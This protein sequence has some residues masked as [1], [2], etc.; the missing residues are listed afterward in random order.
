MGSAINAQPTAGHLPGRW[1]ALG[2]A[3]IYI[4]IRVLPLRKPYVFNFHEYRYNMPSNVLESGLST[5]G[6][7]FE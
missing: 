6:R 7:I 1:P 4:G 2:R 5:Y 3:L